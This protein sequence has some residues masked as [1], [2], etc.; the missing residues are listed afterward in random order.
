MPIS[1][2]EVS[3]ETTICRKDT[4]MQ[5]S[6]LLVELKIEKRII[7]VNKLFLEWCDRWENKLQNVDVLRAYVTFK[8]YN[9]I[10]S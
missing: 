7:A 8:L 10:E 1:A 2:K 6:F 4:S 3:T 5:N 9:A